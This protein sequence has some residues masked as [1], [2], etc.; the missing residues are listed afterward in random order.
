MCRKSSIIIFVGVA[1]AF[2]SL[3]FPFWTWSQVDGDIRR[4]GFNGRSF[5]LSPPTETAYIDAA[6][7]QVSLGTI[8]L[9]TAGALSIVSMRKRDKEAGAYWQ[10]K[11]EQTSSSGDTLLRASSAH[12]TQAQ[13]LLRPA[14]EATSVRSEQ[15]LR[16]DNDSEKEGRG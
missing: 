11:W 12:S 15:L 13:T 2:V 3:M 7:A 5:I 8:A 10:A 1:A 6:S 14:E 16:A 4:D 9:L